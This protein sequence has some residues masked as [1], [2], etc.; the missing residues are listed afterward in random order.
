MKA[1]IVLSINE[2]STVKVNFVTLIEVDKK[3]V[4][5][6]VI[7]I[8]NGYKLENIFN[9]EIYEIS[10]VN[11]CIKLLA[12][13]DKTTM[14]VVYYDIIPILTNYVEGLSNE[15]IDDFIEDFVKN[16]SSILIEGIEM[17]SY[18]PIS[19]NDA[20]E[21]TSLYLV[22][23]YKLISQ[24]DRLAK[25]ISIDKTNEDKRYT[26]KLTN[27]TIQCKRLDFKTIDKLNYKKLFT[28]NAAKH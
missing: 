27:N 6:K 10:N 23:A 20:V 21:I 14:P 19:E 2:T 25:V 8:S 26:L 15:D 16:N 7:E 3:Y 9:K 4:F 13:T 11:N 12:S 5:A 28:I 1:K 17:K 18:V 24:A 22:D